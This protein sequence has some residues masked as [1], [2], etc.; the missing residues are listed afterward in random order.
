MDVKKI[1]GPRV[2]DPDTAQEPGGPEPAREPDGRFARAIDGH[3]AGDPAAARGLEEVLLETVQAV[4][5]G[6][7][8]PAQAVDLILER[9]RQVLATTLP[10]EVDME[11][12]LQYIRETLEGDPVFMSLLEGSRA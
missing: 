2:P 3:A 10:P 9:S 11:D 1:G 8:E 12:V 4:R 6:D 5:R 7:V